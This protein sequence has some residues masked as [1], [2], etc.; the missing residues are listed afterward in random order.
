MP[1]ELGHNRLDPSRRATH[2]KARAGSSVAGNT[3]VILGKAGLDAMRI[4]S[5]G[6]DVRRNS[7]ANRLDVED[8]AVHDWYRFV[9]SFPPHLVRDY[10]TRFELGEEHRVLDPFCG[11]GTTLVECKKCGVPSV[12]VEA[13]T[14][15]CFASRVKVDW[16]PD[17]KRLLA[18]AR[19]VADTALEI[20][21]LQ[22]IDDHAALFQRGRPCNVGARAAISGSG[23]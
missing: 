19:K 17:G 4:S 18:H 8:R 3:L 13:N 6:E 14:M 10:L 1:Q 22:G 2:H 20:L 7:T 12:G 9:M 11:T 21:N 15:A 5:V 16:S 23:A